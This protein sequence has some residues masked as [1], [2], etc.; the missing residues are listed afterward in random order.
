M[1]QMKAQIMDDAAV[2]RALMRIAHEIEE[3]NS[4]CSELCLVGICRRGVPLAQ[5]IAQNIRSFSKI[6]IYVGGLDISNHRDDGRAARKISGTEMNFS[7]E[8]RTVVLVDDVICTGRTVRAAMDALME[9][10]R[11]ACIQLAVLID[12]GHRELPIRGDY[13][14]KNVPTARSEI[15]RVCLPGFDETT[16]VRIYCRSDGEAE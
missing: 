1:V 13:V 14:G 11:P 12:R 15:V 6:K 2:F 5:Q 9:H 10:G 4:S 7:V 3:R 8:G 16:G